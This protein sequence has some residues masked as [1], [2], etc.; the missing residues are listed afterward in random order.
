[1]NIVMRK[2]P[3]GFTKTYDAILANIPTNN[4]VK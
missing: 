2:G 3:V 1:M 4:A